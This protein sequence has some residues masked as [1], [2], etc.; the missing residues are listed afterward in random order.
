MKKKKLTRRTCTQISFVFH[1]L[2]DIRSIRTEKEAGRDVPIL[3]K[4]E[5][6]KLNE[7]LHLTQT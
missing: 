5:D 1:S 2:E 6:A 7:G 3:A 4:H